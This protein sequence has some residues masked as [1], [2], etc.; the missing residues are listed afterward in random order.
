MLNQTSPVFLDNAATTQLCPKVKQVMIENIDVFGNPSSTHYYGRIAKEK[1]ELARKRIAKTLNCKPSEII[2]TG[3]GTEADNWAI[4]GAVRDLG[5][6]RIISSPIEHH[7]VLH[8]LDF[9]KDKY[10][11]E[12]VY[13]PVINGEVNIDDIPSILNDGTKTLVSLMQVNNELGNIT[14][15]E[16]VN[17]YCK[18]YDAYLHSDTVQSIGHINVDFNRLNIDFATCAGHKIHGPKGIGFLYMNEKTRINPL[19]V[20]GSQ[21]RGFR[22]GTENVLSI[23]GLAEAVENACLN[24]ESEMS[25][26]SH[27]KSKLLKSILD[28]NKKFTINTNLNNCVPNVVSLN[29]ANQTSAMTLFKLDL[30]GICVSGGSA[31][32]SGSVSKSHVLESLNLPDDTATIRVSFSKM[33]TEQDVEKLV[34]VLK[35]L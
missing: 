17:H 22:A 1:I 21:E 16:R 34:S 25:H 23:I 30:E 14:D 33:N 27:L 8:T 32:S 2:F 28:D 9:V 35:T 5:V 11:I 3:G 7:A 24:L 13:L 15:I 10:N 26:V 31:C 18:K 6:K 4:I 29:I 19:I 20:G 12:I